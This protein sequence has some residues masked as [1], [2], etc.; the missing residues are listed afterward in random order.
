[1]KRVSLSSQASPGTSSRSQSSQSSQSAKPRKKVVKPPAADLTP[2]AVTFSA[3]DGNW[4]AYIAYV[5]IA[6]VEGN[7][8]AA[9]F[10]KTYTSLSPVQQQDLMPEQICD[11]AGVKPRDLVGIVCGQAYDLKSGES[12]LVAAMSAPRVIA[13]TAKAAMNMKYGNK[14]R[15]LFLR[16]TG[17]LPDKK[18]LPVSIS[19]HNNPQT[20]IAAGGSN[21]PLADAMR[22]R[23]MHEATFELDA[24]VE[25]V[26]TD[27]RAVDRLALE[28]GPA[29][30]TLP[31]IDAESEP[32]PVRVEST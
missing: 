30:V 9:K 27:Q 25:A 16:A 26:V 2:L 21:T 22:L 29:P 24:A 17:K 15:E 14:D 18:G 28:A 1:M 23:P 20:L 32:V 3:L 19:I 12:A 8:L 13:M 4:R 11:M 6:C 5:D 7:E 10:M 31:I